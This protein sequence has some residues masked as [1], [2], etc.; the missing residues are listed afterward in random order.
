[1]RRSVTKTSRGQRVWKSARTECSSAGCGN[2]MNVLQKCRAW[3][4]ITVIDQRD[5][6]YNKSRAELKPVPPRHKWY[7]M[8]TEFSVKTT[9]S[10]PN[11]PVLSGYG[12]KL[13]WGH[14]RVTLSVQYSWLVSSCSAGHDKT[15]WPEL[16]A[17]LSTLCLS[18]HSRMCVCVCVCVCVC[19]RVCECVRVGWATSPSAC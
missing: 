16:T 14:A 5:E 1:M 3:R 9:Q 17:V 10:L 11:T 4:L 18:A 7:H 6:Y 12:V 15:F 19:A 8:K 13:S 2:C